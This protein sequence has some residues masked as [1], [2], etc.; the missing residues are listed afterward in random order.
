[1]PYVVVQ[2]GYQ[3]TIPPQL[4]AEIPVQIGSTMEVL[5][6]NGCYTFSPVPEHAY[7][8]KAPLTEGNRQHKKGKDI[9]KAREL[10]KRFQALAPNAMTS[11][12]VS[13]MYDESGLPT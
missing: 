2:Q 8:E 12:D 7:S 11:T 13:G 4:R 9:E 6:D 5:A 10:A 3:I 1:M